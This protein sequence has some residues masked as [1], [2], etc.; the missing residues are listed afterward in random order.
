MFVASLAVMSSWSLMF[1]FGFN[2]DCGYWMWKCTAC[3]IWDKC[4]PLVREKIHALK[5]AVQWKPKYW[6]DWMLYL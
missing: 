6:D 4:D 1:K 3:N 2:R 5:V